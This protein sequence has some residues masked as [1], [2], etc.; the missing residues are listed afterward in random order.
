MEIP[1]FSFIL[2]WLGAFFFGIAFACW[3]RRDD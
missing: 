3:M 2:F 1:V